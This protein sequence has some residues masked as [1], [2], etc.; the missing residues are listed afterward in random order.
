LLRIGVDAWNLRG[1]R[2]GIGRYLREILTQWN[3]LRDRVS[4]SLIVP[5]WH[6]WTVRSH[7][8]RAVPGC[9]FPVVSRSLHR[10][11]RLDA[12]WF[13]FN[14]CSWLDFD[15]P[16]VATL[17][18]ASPFVLDGYNVDTR[19]LFYN[20]VAR[21]RALITDSIFSQ[22]ELARILQIAPERLIPIPLGVTPAAPAPV[23]P[24]VAQLVP[25]VLFVGAA[26][27]RKG[28]DVA[29]QAFERVVAAH[30]DYTLVLAGSNPVNTPEYETARVRRLGF[31][32][33][34]TL[35]A[36]YRRAA[37]L[38]FPSRYEGFGLPVLEAMARGTPVVAARSSSIPEAGGDAALYVP[39]DDVE[40]FARAMLRAI[41]DAAVAQQLRERGLQRAHAMS[42]HAT[43]LRTLEVFEAL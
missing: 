17:H 13:P 28:L 30:P 40:A 27:E 1:D 9:D 14:G 25:F 19:V 34:A 18:D 31:V 12:L 21:C 26:E 41:D 33:D 23:P 5:E 32:D 16:A 38:A 29:V 2:R 6:T 4:V 43:A 20:A 24:A 11:A 22:H 8:R 7:Y 35:D 36:L 3:T 15:L 10:R 39:P 42:W 37:L